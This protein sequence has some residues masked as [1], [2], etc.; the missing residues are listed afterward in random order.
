MFLLRDHLETRDW[1][2][3]KRKWHAAHWVFKGLFSKNRI[4]TKFMCNLLRIKQ[5]LFNVISR[6]FH[7]EKC[8]GIKGNEM[9]PRVTYNSNGQTY[10]FGKDVP[11]TEER[12]RRNI[13]IC[14]IYTDS[15][16][17]GRFRVKAVDFIFLKTELVTELVTEA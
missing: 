3:E 9:E 1:L 13:N 10:A 12:R 11:S 14:A 6:S 17:E 16:S 4:Q 5:I 8:K 15:T 2:R 7:V